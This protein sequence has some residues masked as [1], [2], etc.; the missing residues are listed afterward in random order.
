MSVNVAIHAAIDPRAAGGAQTS[1]VSLVRALKAHSADIKATLI[2]PPAVETALRE[3]AS[4]EFAV[5]AWGHTFPWYRKTAEQ[6]G[7]AVATDPKAEAREAVEREHLRG[8]RDATLRSLGAEVLHFPYQVTFDSDLP[9]IYEPWDVQHLVLPDLFTPGERDWR[10]A[11]FTRACGRAKLVVVATHA[12]KNDLVSL[13]G[14]AAEKIAVIPRDSRLMRSPASDAARKAALAELKVAE[15]FL[16]YPAMTFAHKNH[17]KL[18]AALALLRDR[19]GVVIPLVCSGRKH[20]PFWPT[21][22]AALSKYRMEK[23]LHFVGAVTDA[24]LAALYSSATAMAFPSRFE[25]LGLP[26]L[27]A[28]QFDLPIAA[29]NASCIPEVTG[30]A[31]LLYDQESAEDIAESLRRIWLDEGIRNDLVQKGRRQR[32][33]NSWEQASRTYLAAYRFCAEREM[34]GEDRARLDASLVSR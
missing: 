7:R 17:V 34:T 22:E 19:H 5:H 18:I 4:P 27:E 8:Q 14:I 29:A 25:G 26:L 20:A 28:M 2:G 9:T 11:L 15:P 33:A 3:V 23:Q 6:E 10:S 1:T 16:L 24:Q 31:A 12:S 32:A 21:I 30:D 13:L